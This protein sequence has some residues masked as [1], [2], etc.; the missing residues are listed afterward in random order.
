MNLQKDR[1]RK[2]I[3]GSAKTRSDPKRYS[4]ELGN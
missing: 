3:V 1:T 4:F 2:R